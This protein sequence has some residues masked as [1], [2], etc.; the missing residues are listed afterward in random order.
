MTATTV[1]LLPG[2]TSRESRY[3]VRAR[4][5]AEYARLRDHERPSLLA[6]FDAAGEGADSVAIGRA[7][8]I[9]DYRIAALAHQLDAEHAPHSNGTV[10]PRCCVLVDRGDGPQW[11]VLAALPED[12]LP[13]ITSDSALGRAL[14]GARRGQTVEYPAPTGPQM[15]RV[16]ALEPA[17]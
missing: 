8:A 5:E 17:A 3:T 13:V 7:I 1:E 15:A 14:I 10:C 9:A 6:E 4:L 16:L 12:G 2:T 11:L